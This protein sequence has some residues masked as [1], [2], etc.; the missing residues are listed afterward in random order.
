MKAGSIQL[1]TDVA[2]AAFDESGLRPAPVCDIQVH[3]TGP[4]SPDGLGLSKFVGG[5][6]C[7]KIFFKNLSQGRFRVHSIDHR[8][9][10]DHLQLRIP[11]VLF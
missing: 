9:K 8:S 2:E 7:A 11:A 4:D 3:A 1:K 6:C 5:C 10:F